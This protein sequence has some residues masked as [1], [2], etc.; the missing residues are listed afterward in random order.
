M[1]KDLRTVFQLFSSIN[2]FV[3]DKDWDIDRMRPLRL[4]ATKAVWKERTL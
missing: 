1:G 3:L 2:S 4:N